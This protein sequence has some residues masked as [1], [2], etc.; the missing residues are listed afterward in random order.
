MVD[1]ARPDIA[2]A[3]RV[4]RIAYS[5]ASAVVIILITVGVS[6][7]QPAAPSVNRDTVYTDTVQRGEMLR[8]VRGTGTLVPEEI[9][10]ISAITNSTVER[11]VLRPGV[12]VEPDTV[13]VELSNPQLEQ[14]A[15]EAQLQLGAARARYKS[16]QVELDR[17]VL[18]QRAGVATADSALTLAVY[19]AELDEEL[20]K[21]ELVSELQLRQKQSR[22]NQLRIQHEIEQQRL[23]I[24]IDAMETQLAA[25]QAEVDRLE[26]IYELRRDEV[27]DLRLTAG[28][29]GVLQEVPLEEGA[30]VTPG[31]NLARVGDPSQLKAELRIAET[32]ASAAPAPSGRILRT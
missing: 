13:I 32:Q 17:D 2:R 6:R 27:A 7:L 25:E 12:T 26:T 20:F 3:K 18:T 16:R 8:Q 19:E 10:W 11:I 24:Q 22:A 15:L 23:E 28:V 30:S 31:T 1:I 21:D 4:R 29:A 5:V 9:R 14:S